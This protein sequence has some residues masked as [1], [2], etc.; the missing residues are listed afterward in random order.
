[1][2]C[3]LCAL[4]SGNVERTD[5][6][7]TQFLRARKH[8]PRRFHERRLRRRWWAANSLGMDPLVD[9]KGCAN[10]AL[11]ATQYLSSRPAPDRSRAD[12]ARNSPRHDQRRF[13]AAIVRFLGHRL[14]Q[15]CVST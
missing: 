13:N 5:D 3:K 4:A 1:M 7:K 2:K 11:S 15:Q 14:N 6:T 10:V 8:R 9:E 12:G